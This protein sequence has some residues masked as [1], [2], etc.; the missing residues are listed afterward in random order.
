ML[1]VED[2]LQRVLAQATPVAEIE[3]VPTF[4]AAGRVLA[5]P[6]A[7]TINVPPMD[8][9]QMDGYAVRVADLAQVPARLPVSQRVAAGHV[10][11]PLAAGTAARIFTGASVPAGADAI[12]MQELT[13]ADGDA[14]VIKE[15]PTAGQ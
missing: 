9:A 1:T 11:A 2:A 7:S 6:V 4:E 5:S 13:E 14:V 10:G 12:V 3:Q 15:L 8:N